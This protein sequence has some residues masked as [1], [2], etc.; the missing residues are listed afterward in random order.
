MLLQLCD[1]SRRFLS[2]LLVDVRLFLKTLQLVPQRFDALQHI[3]IVNLSSGPLDKRSA[4][5]TSPVDFVE[6]IVGIVQV[7]VDHH[8]ANAVG[9]IFGGEVDDCR[10]EI[11][12]N[13]DGSD[14][15]PIGRGLSQ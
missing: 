9:D 13:D 8:V 6:I 14:R 12:P 7:L 10:D 3:R 2:A 1:E 11:L 15:L 5:N 4:S